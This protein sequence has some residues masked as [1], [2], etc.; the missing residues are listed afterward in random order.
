MEALGEGGFDNGRSDGACGGRETGKGKGR[1]EEEV[2]LWDGV[3]I[4]ACIVVLSYFVN[5]MI[6][7]LTPCASRFVSKQ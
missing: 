7:A 6:D 4:P 5:G 2:V 3:Y 1:G